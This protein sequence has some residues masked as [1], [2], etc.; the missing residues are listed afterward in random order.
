MHRSILQARDKLWVLG[1]GASF[2]WVAQGAI[3]TTYVPESQK[4]RAIA[5]FWIN[6]TYH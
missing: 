2:L 3:M 1:V 4:G 6:W 5:A